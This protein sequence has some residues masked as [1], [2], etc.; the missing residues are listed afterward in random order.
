[1]VLTDKDLAP[2]PIIKKPKTFNPLGGVFAGLFLGLSHALMNNSFIKQNVGIGIGV[3]GILLIFLSIASGLVSVSLS[4]KFALFNTKIEKSRTIPAQMSLQIILFYIGFLPPYGFALVYT[5]RDFELWRLLVLGAVY[6]VLTALL[7][8][9]NIRILLLENPSIGHLQKPFW[10]PKKVL[11]ILL[12]FI[13]SAIST[14]FLF[15]V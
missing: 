14:M 15:I 13:P 7:F 8:I 2:K 3:L 4:P 1:M 11:L 9:L 10:Q 6:V 12:S 5:T